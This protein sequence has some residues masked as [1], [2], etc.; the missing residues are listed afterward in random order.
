MLIVSTTRDVSFPHRGKMGLVKKALL[1]AVVGFLAQHGFKLAQ[2]MRFHKI[3]YNH[4]PGKCVQVPGIK[5]GSEDVQLIPDSK[6]ALF[7]AGLQQDHPRYDNVEG[8][9]YMF[10]F[11]RPS[12]G[13]QR[14]RITE[15]FEVHS[16]NPHG[17]SIW[18]SDK[19]G[20]IILFVV[21]HP[22]GQPDVVERF[23]VDEK[24]KV[25]THLETISDP[26]FRVMNDILA[27]DERSFYVTNSLQYPTKICFIVE[28]FGLL[29]VSEVVHYTAGQKGKVVASGLGMAN[30]INMSP[31]GGDV[32]V[33]DFKDSALLVYRRDPTTNDL[34]HKQTVPLY[35]S[36]DNIDVDSLTGELW[37]GC[38]PRLHQLAGRQDNPDYPSSSQ[39][40][41]LKI[42]RK[43]VEIDEVFYDDGAFF[44]ASSV[45][46]YYNGHMLIGSI[47]KQL[48]Y[49]EAKCV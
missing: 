20:K 10:D 42:R 32:Y 40:L 47:D 26:A 31:D 11:Q 25:L 7:S 2:L 12:D 13:A 34:Q 4:K 19:D 45:G 9:I 39:V 46:V 24:R 38:H 21:N 22:R 3:G 36:P 27:T 6:L 1:L 14:M 18:R 43:K 41:K 49:C 8:A 29:H 23:Q 16:F 35:T 28:M 15:M 44:S 48:L 17:I 37:V 5:V 30:G 33:A